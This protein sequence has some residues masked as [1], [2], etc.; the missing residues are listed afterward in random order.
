VLPFLDIGGAFLIVLSGWWLWPLMVGG[1]LG[2]RWLRT[3]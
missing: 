1:A 2:V 3:R